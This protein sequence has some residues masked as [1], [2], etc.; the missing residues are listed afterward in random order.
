MGVFC[1]FAYFLE[2]E[3]GFVGLVSLLLVEAA[4]TCILGNTRWIWALLPLHAWW[5]GEGP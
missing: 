4:S 5:S 2:L 3:R 1:L